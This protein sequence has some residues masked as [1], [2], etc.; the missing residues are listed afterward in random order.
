MPTN[1]SIL[2][3]KM[4]IGQ[5]S[6]HLTS[7]KEIHFVENSWNEFSIINTGCNAI[8]CQYF[9]YVFVWG[10]WRNRPLW[11]WNEVTKCQNR[12]F[13]NIYCGCIFH[14]IFIISGLLERYC[15]LLRPVATPVP[16]DFQWTMFTLLIF[17]RTPRKLASPKQN[18]LVVNNISH[19]KKLKMLTNQNK[20][21]KF[22]NFIN[23]FDL[24]WHWLKTTCFFGMDIYLCVNWY[25][26]Q[27]CI[28]FF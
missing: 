28:I 20:I 4:E 5:V 18:L 17:Q 7:F 13:S 14:Y 24:F 25:L 26:F 6:S 23:F 27:F 2:V 8:L 21:R 15:G 19:P 9:F 22:W 3:G 16:E 1:P 12:P 10:L 11:R